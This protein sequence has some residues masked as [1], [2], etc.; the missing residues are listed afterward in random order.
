MAAS[1][2]T[3]SLPTPYFAHLSSDDWEHVYEP[4]E[5]TFLMMDALE[6]EQE[7]IRSRR[8][9]ILLIAEAWTGSVVRCEVQVIRRQTMLPI[10]TLV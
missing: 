6:A 10:H 2:V 9:G 1:T 4:S 8:S 5:D 3:R 7:T